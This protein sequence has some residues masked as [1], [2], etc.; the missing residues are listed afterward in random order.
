MLCNLYFFLLNLTYYFCH[1]NTM[2]IELVH[3]K[4]KKQ[5]TTSNKLRQQIFGFSFI[6]SHSFSRETHKANISKL[7]DL[8][9]QCWFQKLFRFLLASEVH[10]PTILFKEDFSFFTNLNFRLISIFSN[11]S[12]KFLSL[13]SCFI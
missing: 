3:K 7:D 6:S 10:L 12:A 4:I 13:S 9:C 5:I 2:L 11:R 8:F 1:F